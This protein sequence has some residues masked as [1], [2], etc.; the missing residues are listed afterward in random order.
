MIVAMQIFWSVFNTRYLPNST[1]LFDNFFKKINKCH[2]KRPYIKYVGGGK[3]GGGGGG[4]SAESFCGGH[5][6]F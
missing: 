4:G 1:T 5:E 3:G 2:P 6:I